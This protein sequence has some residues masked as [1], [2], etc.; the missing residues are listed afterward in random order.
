M[1]IGRAIEVSCI[2]ELGVFILKVVL[3]QLM[4]MDIRRIGRRVLMR[5]I[6]PPQPIWIRRA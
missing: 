6:S 3:E 5:R 4:R 2:L 1:E